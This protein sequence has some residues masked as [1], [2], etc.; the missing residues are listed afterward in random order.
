MVPLARFRSSFLGCGDWHFRR[1]RCFLHEEDITEG[2]FHD[3][4]PLQ[5]QDI[6]LGTINF[7]LNDLQK[8]KPP[9]SRIRGKR[10]AAKEKT[11]KSILAGI[12]GL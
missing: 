1:L 4:V 12:Y 3:H 5:M 8:G 11:Y 9:F 6:V 10:T 2:R 7:C